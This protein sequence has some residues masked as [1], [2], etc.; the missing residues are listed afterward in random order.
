MAPCNKSVAIGITFLVVV[1]VAVGVGVGLYLK[2]KH[3]GDEGN[4][5][6]VTPPVLAACPPSLKSNLVLGGGAEYHT[7]TLSSQGIID[8]FFNPTGGP[9]NIF[10]ILHSVDD[11]IR[12]INDRISSFSGCMSNAPTAYSLGTSSWAPSPTFY[13]QCSETWGAGSS[14]PGFDQWGQQGDTTYLYVRGG[15]SITAAALVGNGT[16]GNIAS[17]TIWTSVGMGVTDRNNF[18]HCVVMVYAEPSNTI[19]EMSVAGSNIGYCGAQLKSDGVTMNVTGSADGCA[20][21]DSACTNAN[22]INTPAVCSTAVNT[23]SLPAL[24]RKAYSIWP[25]SAY[26]GGALNTV[27]LADSGPVDDAF[28]GPSSPT[29]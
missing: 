15:D 16:F 8:R 26:P 17:V 23:F 22:S 21:T 29:V 27:Q 3:N 19:F 14:V 25:A 18:S 11:R 5:P 2:N 6:F 24:G 28:F 9:T 1:G 20:P 13:A 7:Q 4:I 10:D 12:S